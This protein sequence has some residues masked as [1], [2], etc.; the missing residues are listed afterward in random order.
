MAF[1]SN[2]VAKILGLYEDELLLSQYEPGN[3]GKYIMIK[4]LPICET[5]GDLGPKRKQGD[6]QIFYGA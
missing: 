6:L 2:M 3:S 4:S 1:E 5:I